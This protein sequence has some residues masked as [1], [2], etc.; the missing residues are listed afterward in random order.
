MAQYEIHDEWNA[1]GEQTL[2]VS[3]EEVESSTREKYKRSY[4]H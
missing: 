2:A 4:H 1:P 3:F